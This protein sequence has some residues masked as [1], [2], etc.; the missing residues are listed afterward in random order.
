M[1]RTLVTAGLITSPESYCATA[2][3][4]RQPVGD[5]FSGSLS[6]STLFFKRRIKMYTKFSD[7]FLP[8]GGE[9]VDIKNT[10]QES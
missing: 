10:D 1:W 2:G 4:L 6:F 5:R 9:R 3:L 8:S 7:F